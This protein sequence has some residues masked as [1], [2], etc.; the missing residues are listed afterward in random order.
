MFKVYVDMSKQD[1]PTLKTCAEVVQVDGRGEFYERGWDKSLHRF[2][3]EPAVRS[4]DILATAW[5]KTAA[6]AWVEAEAILA[7]VSSRV[8]LLREEC[9]REAASAS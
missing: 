3:A 5:H 1:R 2:D 9:R 4:G 7:G 8:E 6:E